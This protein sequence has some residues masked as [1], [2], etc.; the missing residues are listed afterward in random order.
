[1]SRSAAVERA[2]AGR[3]YKGRIKENTALEKQATKAKIMTR[4]TAGG[5]NQ[6]HFQE[7]VD[8]CGRSVLVPVTL[9]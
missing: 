8:F 7:R 2:E 1:M 9:G 3:K 5:G 6:W 4:R